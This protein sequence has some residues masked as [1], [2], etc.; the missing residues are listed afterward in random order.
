MKETTNFHKLENILKSNKGYITREDVDKNN[1][2]SWFLSDFVRRKGLEKIAPG[3]Y[4]NEAYIVD[5]YYILQKRYP[6]YIY[7]GMSALYLLSLTDK[8]VTDLE[9]V[10]PQG[11][12]PSREKNNI[13]IRRISD[14]K[15]YSLG[16]TSVKTMF[17]YSVQTYDPE[18]TI[19]DLVKY[20]D[21]Y[22]AET[23]VKAVRFY[24]RKYNDQIKLM[25]YAKILGVEKKVFEI[26]ELVANE[27]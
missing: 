22:D 23:F 10:A 5:D 16:V 27:D 25:R 6:K 19:C 26:M 11:Y 21:E 14:S 1:I 9:V 24:I 7:A 4:A 8:I 15:K 17:G 2:P 12:N 18:R 13:S 20:R 3:F